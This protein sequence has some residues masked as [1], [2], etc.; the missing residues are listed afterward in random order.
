MGPGHMGLGWMESVQRGSDWMWSGRVLLVGLGLNGVRS[1]AV[2]SDGA[3]L[4]G[5][6][7]EGSDWMRSVRLDVVGRNGVS[8]NGFW[9]DKIR[10]D[11]V[12]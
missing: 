4:D 10:S 1:D 8:S 7:S 11:V 3:R 12:G 5:V 2:G 6:R 9:L